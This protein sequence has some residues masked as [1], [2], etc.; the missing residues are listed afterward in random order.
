[1]I[2]PLTGEPICGVQA[3]FWS[4]F[5]LW[6]VCEHE[7]SFAPV[8]RR[9]KRAATLRM[10]HQA[11]GSGEGLGGGLRGV[12]PPASRC[13]IADNGGGAATLEEAPDG[14]Q[15]PLQ[16]IAVPVL[17]TPFDT[18]EGMPNTPAGR[19]LVVLGIP[20]YTGLMEPLPKT[21]AGGCDGRK[22]DC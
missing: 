5:F 6:C 8:W 9:S 1:M 2:I 3:R 18:N 20:C 19:P 14:Q 12:V 21:A 13:Q 7:V 15:L 11:G 22:P 4:G 10:G 16:R 17:C